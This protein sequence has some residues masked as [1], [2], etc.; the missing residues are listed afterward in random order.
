MCGPHSTSTRALGIRLF[1]GFALLL[2]AVTAIDDFNPDGLQRLSSTHFLSAVAVDDNT[3]SPFLHHDDNF[4]LNR[5]QTGCGSS[6]HACGEFGAAGL[7]CASNAVCS[8]DASGNVA[9]CPVGAVCTGLVAGGSG[10]VVTW[11]AGGA[12]TSTVVVV[13]G[14]GGVVTT[15]VVYVGG[16][17]TTQAQ[18]PATVVVTTT[19]AAT[20]AT[21]TATGGFIVAAGTTVALLPNG[22][23]RGVMQVPWLLRV[24]ATWMV[25]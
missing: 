2:S 19:L 12:V 15:T 13:V 22:G 20:R 9:C 18:T 11:T 5:R 10:A 8:A 4:N 7:C 6:Y 25:H 23:A 3:T 21:A 14:G 17:A 1:F 16:Q 24:L